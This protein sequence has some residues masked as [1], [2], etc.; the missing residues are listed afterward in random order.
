[1]HRNQIKS[2]TLLS[3][4]LAVA[5]TWSLAPGARA[6]EAPG[7]SDAENILSLV[8]ETVREYERTAGVFETIDLHRASATERRIARVLKKQRVSFQLVDQDVKST[9]NILRDITGLN[10]MI[11]GKARK[12][13]KVDAPK[14]T[15][16]LRDLPLENVLNLLALQ[17]G[18]YRFTVR[19]GVLQ[20]ITRDEFRVRLKLRVYD[21]HDIL[22][23]PRDFPAPRLGLEDFDQ[24][25]A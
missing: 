18:E 19:Y 17:L 12:A 21:I 15:V 5:V 9:L 13:L 10:F 2:L 3:S 7:G 14:V 11:S 20:L 23:R 24:R 4:Y 1:M 16:E 22:Y 25:D 8:E 6:D